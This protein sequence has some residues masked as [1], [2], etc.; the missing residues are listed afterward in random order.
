MSNQG[1]ENPINIE[2]QPQEP[3]FQLPEPNPYTMARHRSQVLRQIT[4]PFVIA[5]IIFL[6]FVVLAWMATSPEAS[7][8]ADV[9]ISYLAV[10]LLLGLIIGILFSAA[11]AYLIIYLNKALPPYTRLIQDYSEQ[12]RYYAR[13]YSDKAVKPII[14]TESNSAKMSTLKRILMGKRK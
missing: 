9:S 10:L 11:I 13:V 6:V 14:E 3:E 8:W 1:I 5:L 4:I 12:A 2:M 7:L